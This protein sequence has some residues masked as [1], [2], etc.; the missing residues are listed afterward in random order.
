MTRTLARLAVV[1]ALT[2]V[3]AAAAADDAASAAL[4][5]RFYVAFN[6]RDFEAFNQFIAADFVDH[7]ARPD[8]GPGVA[9]VWAEM[10]A[11]VAEI[12][13][14]RLTIE[15]LLVSGDYVTVVL[16][17][18][19]MTGGAMPADQRL[20]NFQTIDVWL[21]RDGMLAEIWHSERPM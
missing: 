17:A 8:G 15:L 19:G 18:R 20:I 5:R 9:I 21:I 10:E 2:A 11:L 6:D 16:S 3:P 1:L 14:V 7:S 4:A 13:N 12:P